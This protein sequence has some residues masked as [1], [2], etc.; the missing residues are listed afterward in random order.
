MDLFEVLAE[1]TR[2]VYDIHKIY[3]TRSYPISNITLVPSLKNVFK[4]EKTL[5]TLIE[6]QG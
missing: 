4:R 3:N 1:D 6:R 2:P 5:K